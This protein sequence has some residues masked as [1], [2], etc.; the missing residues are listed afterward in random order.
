MLRERLPELPEAPPGGESG[1]NLDAE[2]GFHGRGST[3]EN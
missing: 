1:A 2:T 3:L